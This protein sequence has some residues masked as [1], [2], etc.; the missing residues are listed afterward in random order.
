MNASPAGWFPDPLGRY[1]YRY[2]N[3]AVWTAD[4]SNGGNRL[5]DP[6]GTAPQQASSGPGGYPAPLAAAGAGGAFGAYEPPKSNGIAVA[7]LVCGIIGALIAWAPFVVIF[8]LILAILAVIFGVQGL[9]RAKEVDKGR[10]VAL[11]GLILGVAGIVLSAIGIWL[12]VVV[13]R[14]V[15]D[16][17]EPGP[18]VAEVTGCRSDG[19]F[20][21]A[22][23]TLTNR[24]STRR[25]Y[26]LFVEIEGSRGDRTLI[27][28]LTNVAPG[29]TVE[30]EVSGRATVDAGQCEADVTV[31]GP[32]P[33]GIELDPI[34]S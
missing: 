26:T 22:G 34:E 5:V 32:F 18:V 24:S 33:F 8:G 10:G 30:W 31:Q 28:Q 29:E 25:D 6:N 13:W 27:D 7:A 2:F 4:V 23:G 15:V 3:G 17:I 11:A 20:V 19:V 9:K 16:F 14:E 12:T 1:E 21:E